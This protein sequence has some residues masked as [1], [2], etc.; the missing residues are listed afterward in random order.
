MLCPDQVGAEIVECGCL[1]EL[2][3]L[4]VFFSSHALLVF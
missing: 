2:V 1:I 3:D 4:K